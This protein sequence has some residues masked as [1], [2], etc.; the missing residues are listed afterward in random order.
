MIKI[1]II[2]YHDRLPAHATV[3]HL[4]DW[5]VVLVQINSQLILWQC[6][7]WCPPWWSSWCH[8]VHYDVHHDD[9]PD[10]MMSTMMSIMMSTMM[11]TMMCTMMTSTMMIP[12]WS[13]NDV[14]LH[15]GGLG[16][17]HFHL[18]TWGQASRL[19]WR[20]LTGYLN[21]FGWLTSFF[22]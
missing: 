14:N 5:A 11:S 12:W 7:L 21:T 3:S 17:G 10:V 19:V 8:D 16:R 22:L 15:Q 1:I 20:I 9:H 13:C 4:L 18:R 2:W 6:P